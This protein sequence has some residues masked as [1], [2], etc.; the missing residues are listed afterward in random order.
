MKI[1]CDFDGTA[2]ANDVG[3]LLFRKYAGDGCFDIIQLWKDGKISSR[4]CLLRECEIT[5]V[6]RDEL[7]NFCDQQK[8]AAFFPEFLAYC[9]RNDIPVEIVSDGLDFYVERILTNHGLNGDVDFYANKLHF[10]ENAG[11]TAEFPYFEYGCGRCANCKGYHVKKA[12]QAGFKVIYVG[13]GL[14]DRCGADAADIVFA[15]IGR[16][17]ERYCDDQKLPHHKFDNFK[18]VLEIIKNSTQ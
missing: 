6:T 8:L 17:L 13:D 1:L 12:K 11:I 3:N 18:D 7:G 10:L 5:S 4:E 9:E 2:A 14:S 16:D 15:K